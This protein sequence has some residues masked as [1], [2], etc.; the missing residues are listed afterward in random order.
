MYI[1]KTTMMFIWLAVIVVTLIIEIITQGLTTIWFSIGA[2]AAAIANNWEPPLWIQ[3]AIFCVV[4]ILFM[5][6]AR[7]FAQRMM[8]NTITPTNIDQL[9]HEEGIVV[10]VFT[11]NGID[12]ITTRGEWHGWYLTVS[13]HVQNQCRIRCPRIRLP[14]N[15]PAAQLSGFLLVYHQDIPEHHSIASHRTDFQAIPGRRRI[16]FSHF[17]GRIGAGLLCLRPRND[18][19]GDRRGLPAGIRVRRPEGRLRVR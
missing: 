13:P 19:P 3:I 12:G 4:S 6:L 16:C 17:Q 11:A 18:L 9:L 14:S 5:L 15:L 8:R 2:A 1:D 7:P 10:E